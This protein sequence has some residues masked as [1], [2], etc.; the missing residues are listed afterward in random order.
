MQ[1]LES[2]LVNHA[3]SL[4]HNADARA[5]ALEAELASVKEKLAR[6]MEVIQTMGDG[7]ESHL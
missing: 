5:V 4:A 6:A 1:S 2:N 3:I 7:S